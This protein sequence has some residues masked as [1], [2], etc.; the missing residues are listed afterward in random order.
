MRWDEVDLVARTWTLPASRTK[1]KRTHEIPLSDS[2]VEILGAVARVEGKAGFVFSTTGRT[3][4]SGFSCAKAAI[5]AAMLEIM[6]A[7]AEARGNDSDGVKVAP[8]IIHDLRRTVATNLQRLGVKLE[9]TEAVLNHVSGS[10][11]GI[12]GVYQRHTWADEKR[13]ALDAWSR[14]LSEIVTDEAARAGK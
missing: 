7:D 9:V 2:A 1:N 3:S 8:W 4:V 14:R 6:R 12:I 11:S 5:D 10:R 13:A